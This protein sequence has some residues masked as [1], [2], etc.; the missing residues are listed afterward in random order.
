MDQQLVVVVLA[1]AVAFHM[2]CFAV[3]RQPMLRPFQGPP[4]V[5]EEHQKDLRSQLVLREEE[6]HSQLEEQELGLHILQKDRQSEQ[7]ELVEQQELRTQQ[8]DQHPA[9]RQEQHPV[10]LLEAH[11]KDF[12]LEEPHTHLV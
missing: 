9:E 5:A 2:D 11:R 8:M 4:E 10:A 7:Q 12:A 3:A 6:H 1:A